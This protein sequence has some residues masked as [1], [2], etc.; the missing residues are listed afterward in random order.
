VFATIVMPVAG[1]A[2]AEWPIH[3][4]GADPPSCMEVPNPLGELQRAASSAKIPVRV[5]QTGDPLSSGKVILRPITSIHAN[6]N[7]TPSRVNC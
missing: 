7:P 5:L 4:R 1:I 3:F 6:V 2:A